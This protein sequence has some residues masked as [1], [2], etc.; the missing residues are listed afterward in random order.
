MITL[1]TVVFL[2]S[3]GPVFGANN[4]GTASAGHQNHRNKGLPMNPGEGAGDDAAV[5]SENKSGKAGKSN[6]VQPRVIR[7]AIVKMP[8]MRF[9]QGS[10]RP[11]YISKKTRTLEVYGP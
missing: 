10:K 2:L 7:K 8:N 11:R 1:L 9:A 6:T 4:Q 5:G 3:T